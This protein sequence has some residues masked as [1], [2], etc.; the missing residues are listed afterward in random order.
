VSLGTLDGVPLGF[1]DASPLPD[2]RLLF[3]AAAEAGGS[4]YEDGAATGSVLGVLDCD[5]ARVQAQRRLATT[6]KIEG[7]HASVAGDRLR[8]YLVADGDDRTL[9]APLYGATLPLAALD[10]DILEA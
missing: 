6:D 2:G 9:R 10:G 5:S 8:L 7:L 1:T 3:A 4:T